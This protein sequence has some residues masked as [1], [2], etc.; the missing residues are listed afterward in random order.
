MAKKIY[1]STK[2]KIL[3]GTCGGFG[4]YFNIDPLFVRMIFIILVFAGT[5]G[6]WIYILT[7]ILMPARPAEDFD[8]FETEDDEEEYVNMKAK[9][10]N[11]SVDIDDKFDS[12]FEK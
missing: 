12:Y 7:A 4:E 9:G 11:G 2:N 3:T 1:K 5:S 6:I 10:E 8:Q